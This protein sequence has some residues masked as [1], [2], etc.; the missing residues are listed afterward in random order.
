MR[1]QWRRSCTALVLT[2]VGAAD[3]ELS[4][5]EQGTRGSTQSN[6]LTIGQISLRGSNNT[7]RS[8]CAI[9]SHHK[10]DQKLA[11]SSAPIV[12]TPSVIQSRTTPQQRLMC[13][14]ETDC[15]D[16]DGGEAVYVGYTN[17]VLAPIVAGKS[18]VLAP[19]VGD[20][21][22]AVEDH[23]PCAILST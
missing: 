4:L 14:I 15:D 13:T 11:Q 9:S 2:F 16:I 19:C 3:E 6:T 7:C 1:G 17:S 5:S 8:T 20:L 10:A 22:R 18:V 21:S 23:G 12:K